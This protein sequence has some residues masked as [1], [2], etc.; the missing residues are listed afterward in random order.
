[1]H[2]LLLALLGL[3][4][5]AA[6]LGLLSRK[7]TRANLMWYRP[8]LHRVP[9]AR[10]TTNDANTIACLRLQCVMWNITTTKN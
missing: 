9:L 7:K 10:A 8:T 6:V 5:F 3:A 4:L 2:I 1:M